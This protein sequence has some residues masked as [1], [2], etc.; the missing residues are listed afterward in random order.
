LDS[1]HK[2]FYRREY[3]ELQFKIDTYS[4]FLLKALKLTKRGGTFTYIIPSTFLDNFFEEK[5]RI[6]LL[7]KT[8]IDRIV[9]LN[10]QVF[11]DAVVHSM[12]ISI[13]NIKPELNH[14]IS[15][16]ASK[17]IFTEFAEVPVDY[18]LN[19]PQSALSMRNFENKDF[20]SKIAVDT[21]SL[22]DVLDIRQAIKTGNDKIYLYNS[23]LKDNF[24]PIIGGKHIGKYKII[25]SGIFVDYG[26]HLACPRDYK[27]FEQPKILIRE[28][29]ST[30]T[31]TYDDSGLYVLS[32]LYNA[33]LKDKEFSLKY[34]LA[35]INSKL[36]QY[37]MNLLTLE[38]TSGAFTKARIFHYYK[39][40]IKKITS[41]E[42]KPFVEKVEMIL[43]MKK[44][45]IDTLNL[46]NDLDLMV[47]KL[48]K[49][50]IDEQKIID[51][52]K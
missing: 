35:L 6:N 41:T 20:L 34:I 47:Y 42:Q 2:D 39:L 33:I 38:K 3:P 21:V 52:L 14:K 19:Q 24:K 31:A 23:K 32:S 43:K 9:E 27:I 8:R 15:I 7:T 46:E 49:L 12:I 26:K 44:E 16:S 28:T 40:P 1:L 18:I 36:F 25:D 10:D 22:I 45:G 11:P 37:M 30:I 50:S 48:Y 13:I 51:G 5:I 17:S 29:G 4:M